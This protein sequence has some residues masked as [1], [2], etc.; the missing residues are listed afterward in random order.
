MSKKNYPNPND[1]P[2]QT[3][4]STELTGAGVSTVNTEYDPHLEKHLN[5]QMQK[6]KPNITR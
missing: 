3:V 5:H 1:V 2:A 4:L 6:R